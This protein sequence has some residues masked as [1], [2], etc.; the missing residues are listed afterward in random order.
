M[1]TQALSF[2]SQLSGPAVKHAKANYVTKQ[3]PETHS[4]AGNFFY[5]GEAL[6]FQNKNLSFTTY[7]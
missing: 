2:L 4:L 5:I 6:Q 3:T 7:L 1:I